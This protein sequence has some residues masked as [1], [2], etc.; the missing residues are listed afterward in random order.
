MLSFPLWMDVVPFSSKALSIP[1]T[2]ILF[3]WCSVHIMMFYS[4][5]LIFVVLIIQ[6]VYHL[7]FPCN[8]FCDSCVIWK[9]RILLNIQS[10]WGFLVVIVLWVHIILG[11]GH[12]LNGSV[13]WMFHVYLNI[14][15]VVGAE[16][17]AMALEWL[18][19]CFHNYC[20]RNV[21][22]SNSDWRLI[23]F[24]YLCRFLLRFSHSP[25]CITFRIFM[26]SLDTWI[27]IK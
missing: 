21:K 2:C 13:L 1:G 6:L 25:I 4:H 27:S 11:R 7:V 5:T 16:P 22:I 12:I 14:R 18:F 19:S 24:S 23:Y 26:S 8:L 10:F 3:H 20:G 9:Y 17:C 15:L